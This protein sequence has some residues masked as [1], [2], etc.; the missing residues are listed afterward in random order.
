MSTRAKAAFWGVRGRVGENT[1]RVRRH[2]HI[3]GGPWQI[4]RGICSE[5]A[6]PVQ[7]AVLAL[8]RSIHP[9]AGGGRRWATGGL[10]SLPWDSVLLAEPAVG[11][12]Y[13][14]WQRELS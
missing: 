9:M 7:V 8:V 6:S 5:C 12:H 1:D 13:R 2:V 3:C 14:P 11:L 4:A 10:A